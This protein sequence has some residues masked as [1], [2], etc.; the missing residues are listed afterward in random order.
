MMM[1]G[2]EA[3]ILLLEFFLTPVEKFVAFASSTFT[4]IS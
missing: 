4:P 1:E 3:A 2:M